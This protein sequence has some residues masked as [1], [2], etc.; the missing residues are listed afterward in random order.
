MEKQQPSYC[1]AT[2][3][4]VCRHFV[5][6]QGGMYILQLFDFYGASGFT[7]LWTASWQC[8]AISWFYGD[9][10]FYD[11]IEDMIGYR[12]TSFFR[13]CWKYFSPLLNLVSACLPWY[14][15]EAVF[16][17]D[18]RD[19]V[20]SSGRQATRNYSLT[21]ICAILD[22]KKIPAQGVFRLLFLSR[23]WLL[24]LKLQRRQE[25]CF[26]RKHCAISKT[27]PRRVSFSVT[28]AIL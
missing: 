6:V 5:F 20:S 23:M 25:L 14:V 28:F 2:C 21:S 9:Q 13:L 22:V 24:P 4:A 1:F 8:I 18:V 11:V 15:S 19:V 10:K 17:Q 27:H 3:W 16:S 12:P 7:L 26:Y